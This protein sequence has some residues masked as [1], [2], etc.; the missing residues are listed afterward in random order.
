[1]S[2]PKKRQWE[3]TFSRI[4]YPLCLMLTASRKLA[5]LALPHANIERYINPKPQTLN[6]WNEKQTPPRR[7][8]VFTDTIAVNDSVRLYEEPKEAK[9]CLLEQRLSLLFVT[10]VLSNHSFCGQE[11]NEQFNKLEYRLTSA[12]GFSNDHLL[13]LYHV[14]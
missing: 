10:R 6:P 14:A 9:P 8:E 1:M 11:E 13:P 3:D 7:T 5:E 2:S 12:M 4:R